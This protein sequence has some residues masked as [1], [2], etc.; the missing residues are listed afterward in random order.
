MQLNEVCMPSNSED[1]VN[2]A[3]ALAERVGKSHT[4]IEDFLRQAPDYKKIGPLARIVDRH[5]RDG[6]DYDTVC[7]NIIILRQIQNKNSERNDYADRIQAAVN[8]Y[9]GKGKPEGPSN[10]EPEPSPVSGP[11]HHSLTAQQHSSIPR[12][13]GGEPSKYPCNSGSNLLKARLNFILSE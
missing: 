12:R 4:P 6:A 1:F 3:K 11:G 9:F 5:I 13:V 2:R 8:Q 10:A 7:A